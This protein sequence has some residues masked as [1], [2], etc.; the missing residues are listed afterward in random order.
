MVDLINLIQQ[1]HIDA[2]KVLNLGNP[3]DIIPKTANLSGDEMEVYRV[4]FISHRDNLKQSLAKSAHTD[5][6]A[7]N[8]VKEI[9]T[10]IYNEQLR[11][12]CREWEVKTANSQ[13][14]TSMKY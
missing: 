13:L 2:V 14:S 5:E 1:A 3:S 10:P 12:T 4:E 11:N 7:Y 8:M 9:V 6:M